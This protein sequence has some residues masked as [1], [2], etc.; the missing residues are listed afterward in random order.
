MYYTLPGHHHVKGYTA[1]S[2]FAIDIGE[3]LENVRLR[4]QG[5]GEFREFV[6]YL[7]TKKSTGVRGLS[8]FLM[9][10]E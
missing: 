5:G 2:E 9:I 10:W 3:Y 4:K 8:N 1:L 6:A 7:L